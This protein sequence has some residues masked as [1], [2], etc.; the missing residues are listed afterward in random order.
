MYKYAVPLA[1]YKLVHLSHFH[2]KTKELFTMI[3]LP[4]IWQRVPGKALLFL[5][6]FV[7][8]VALIF[9]GNLICFV[10]FRLNSIRCLR[11]ELI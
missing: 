8:A 9:E 5:I 3:A 7:S 10:C 1:R 11:A 2:V 4:K 6:N